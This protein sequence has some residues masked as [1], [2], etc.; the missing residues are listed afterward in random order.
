MYNAHTC[1]CVVHVALHG[2]PDCSYFTF[3]VYIHGAFS[4]KFSPV[5]FF[6][7]KISLFDGI[8]S[9]FSYSFLNPLSD[10]FS[11]ATIRV[12]LHA[13]KNVYS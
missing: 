12:P 3:F 11:M 13:V 1:T 7:V 5:E 8:V 9:I 6:Q 4:E 10:T 2:F